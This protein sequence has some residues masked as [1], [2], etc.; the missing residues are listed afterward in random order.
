VV[1][2]KREVGKLSSVKDR[3]KRVLRLYQNSFNMGSLTMM[4]TSLSNQNKFGVAE[5]ELREELVQARYIS[6]VCFV[7]RI[8]IK[9]R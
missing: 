9:D 3:Y 1:S 6:C 4:A 2:L 7:K 5:V 8:F